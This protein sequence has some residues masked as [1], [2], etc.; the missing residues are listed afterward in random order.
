MRFAWDVLVVC[1][2][3]VLSVDA[4]NLSENSV[5]VHSL[6]VDFTERRPRDACCVVDRLCVGASPL[7]AF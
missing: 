5:Q 2:R 1:L 6:P 4:G 7:T 3:V